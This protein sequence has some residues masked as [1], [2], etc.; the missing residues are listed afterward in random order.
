MALHGITVLCRLSQ[1]N[2]SY[3]ESVGRG[4][5]I[6]H[7]EPHEKIDF[8]LIATGSEVWLALQVATAL[9]K[10]GKSSRVISM[11]CWE[12]FDAQ[13]LPYRKE[14]LPR[15]GKR[16]S[17]EAATSFGWH[18]WIG[19]DGIHISVDRFGASAP[20]SDLEQEYG[21]TVDSILD[22]LLS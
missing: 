7:K 22:R 9:E 1:S 17:I 2:L 16:V 12:L 18:K 10:L 13:P 3:E 20:M 5:Y 11:P 8:V 14:V 6:L 21:F 19:E 4:A 15:Q